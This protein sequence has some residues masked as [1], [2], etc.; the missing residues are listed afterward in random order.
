MEAAAAAAQAAVVA[1]TALDAAEAIRQQPPG[2]AEDDDWLLSMDELKQWRGDK[3]AA[4]EAAPAEAAYLSLPAP[5][6]AAPA[7]FL[8]PSKLP[9]ATKA[10]PHALQWGGKEKLPDSPIGDDCILSSAS[11]PPPQADRTPGSRPSAAAR[12]RRFSFFLKTPPSASAAA[13]RRKSYAFKAPGQASEVDRWLNDGKTPAKSRGLA[14]LSC[15]GEDD[16]QPAAAAPAPAVAA[17][18]PAPAAAAK[19]KLVQAPGSKMVG[20]L[21]SKAAPKAAPRPRGI[22]TA[23]GG[24]PAAARPKVKSSGY[25]QVR[26]SGYGQPSRLGP[27]RASAAPK[28]APKREPAARPTFSWQ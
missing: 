27:N 22:P 23:A 5:A 4:E 13:N 1:T 6:E 9:R 10:S 11:K 18:A 26:S 2:A 25:G 3:P 12:A 20:S 21:G 14:G 24:I 19:P 28:P 7:D 17:P 15:I 16:E 8:S